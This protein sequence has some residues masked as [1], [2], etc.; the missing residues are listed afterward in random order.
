MLMSTPSL[1]RF[2]QLP[3]VAEILDASM[4]Q[5]LA[6]VRR[7]DLRAVKIGGRGQWRVEVTEL[8]AYIQRCYAETDALIASHDAELPS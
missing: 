6:L 3:D 7:G 8:E 2:L 5:V 4:S 1:R